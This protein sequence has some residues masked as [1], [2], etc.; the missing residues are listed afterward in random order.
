LKL[1]DAFCC[2]TSG[3]DTPS[4]D[5]YRDIVENMHDRIHFV[6]RERRIT[7]W[8]KGARRITGYSAPEVVGTPCAENI[9]V[10]VDVLRRKLCK[11]L[12]RWS[13]QW[14]PAPHTK[15]MFT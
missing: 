14:P 13:P 3:K 8:N 7:Y 12:C 2:P 6:D 1:N 5:L 15:P 4:E 10:H 9:I 11:G